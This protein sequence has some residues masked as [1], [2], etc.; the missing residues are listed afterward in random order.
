M[1]LYILGIGTLLYFLGVYFI[2]LK[3]IQILQFKHQN[4]DLWVG[5]LIFSLPVFCVIDY[6][7][8][9]YQV[10]EILCQI[11]YVV[12][13][14]LIYY[15]LSL[16]VVLAIRG[17][18]HLITKKK[19][20]LDRFTI[21]CSGIASI[22]I[23]IFGMICAQMNTKSYETYDLNLQQDLK[24]VAISDVHYGATGSKVSLEKLV[25][26]INE[27]HP[28]VV[29]F[30]GDV[31]DNQVEKLDQSFFAATLAKIESTYG[32]FAITG[33]HELMQNSM[34]EIQSFYQNS[35]INLL[36]DEAVTIAD[37]LTIYGRIDYKSTARTELKNNLIKTNHPILVLDHQPQFYRD[38]MNIN[39]FLQLSGHTH[40][41]QIFPGNLLIGILNKWK[42]N[43][44]TNGVHEYGDFTLSITRGYGTW[45]FPMR[46]T[47]TSEMLVIT[48]K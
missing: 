6:M 12:A 2:V 28:D 7:H 19:G 23:C 14:F 41:G 13:G 37:E 44:P 24:I 38:S 10:I 36:L 39:A 16:L 27:E 42:Y 11:G 18:Y 5:I 17:I 26:Q 43:S 30:L 3:T 25:E 35:N 33:N 1:G 22:L 46:L 4:I 32:V 48:L 47:G 15:S 31:F 45:G 40:N 9:G 8:R 21:Y 34:Q 29:L 20:I